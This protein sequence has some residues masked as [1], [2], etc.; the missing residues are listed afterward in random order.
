MKTFMQ[1]IKEEK[2]PEGSPLAA[3][4]SKTIKT[5]RDRDRLTRME[6]MLH[7]L[8]TLHELIVDGRMTHADNQN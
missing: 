8:I 5:K 7:E 4:N 6:T 2:K 1:W 3:T